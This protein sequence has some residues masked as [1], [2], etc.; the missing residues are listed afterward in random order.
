MHTIFDDVLSTIYCVG[1][2]IYL[3][4]KYALLCLKYFAQFNKTLYQVMI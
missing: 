3:L 1:F 4:F 2:L